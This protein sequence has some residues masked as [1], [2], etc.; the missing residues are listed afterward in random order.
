[1]CKHP[2]AD[3]VKLM[4][5]ASYIKKAPSHGFKRAFALETMR[6]F[7]KCEEDGF[8]IQQIN[9]MLEVGYDAEVL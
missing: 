3:A 4:L 5:L 1:M 9:D 8:T 7:E 2:L 6:Y